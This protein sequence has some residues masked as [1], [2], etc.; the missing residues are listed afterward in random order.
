MN[1]NSNDDQRPIEGRA[2]NSSPE[3]ESEHPAAFKVLFPA[4]Q[5]GWGRPNDIPDRPPEWMRASSHAELEREL[6]NV[7][8]VHKIPIGTELAKYLAKWAVCRKPRGMSG[9]TG[10]PDVT[11]FRRALAGRVPAFVQWAMDHPSPHCDLA[12]KGIRAVY[13]FQW[14]HNA[15]TG[16]IFYALWGW[17]QLELR[18][19]GE[20]R[21]ATIAEQMAALQASAEKRGET[22]VGWSSL[23]G[24]GVMALIGPKDA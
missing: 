1:D 7:P 20:S 24:C 8:E 12:V 9:S 3:A 13:D 11:F 17:M 23:G 15:S 2:N 16:Y 4:I 19:P 6:S 5:G 18:K 10:E 22:I 21:P 14:P